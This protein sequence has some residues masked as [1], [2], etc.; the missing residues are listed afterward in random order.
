ME[1]PIPDFVQKIPTYFP[2][3]LSLRISTDFTHTQLLR[4]IDDKVTVLKKITTDFLEDVPFTSRNNESIQEFLQ[5]QTNAYAK[6]VETKFRLHDFQSSLRQ[7]HTSLVNTRRLEDDVSLE[8]YE[9][10][11]EMTKKNFADAIIHDAD[12]KA[13]ESHKT[14][15]KADLWYQYVRN[16]YFVI[17]H[18]EDPLPDDQ[19]DEELAM[20]GGKI[21]LKDP[22]SLNYFVDPVLSVSCKHVFEKEHIMQLLAKETNLKCPITG[23]VEMITKKDLLPDLLM[24]LRVKAHKA[25]ER[26]REKSR[27]TRVQ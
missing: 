18:P 19:A 1:E 16:A 11:C 14:I 5:T 13:E 10:Y 3:H 21:S 26:T 20:E 12:E 27:A 24:K 7:A 9:T 17:Q 2:V 25:K 15:L 4:E 6:L 22:L 8:N 23:C